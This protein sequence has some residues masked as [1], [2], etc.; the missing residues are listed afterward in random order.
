MNG[1]ESNGKRSKLGPAVAIVSTAALA[2]GVCCVLPFA[3]PAAVLALGG[4]VLAW[5]ASAYGLMKYVSVAAVAGGWI[6]VATQSVRTKKRPARTTLT[7]MI[8]ASVILLL[9]LLWPKAAGVI[10]SMM[11]R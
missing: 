7:T 2:C 5:F 6:W 8:G 10:V 3:L 4:G 11:T 9:A 1:T